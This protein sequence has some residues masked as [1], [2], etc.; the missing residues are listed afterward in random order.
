[1]ELH[2]VITEQSSSCYHKLYI[3]LGRHYSQSFK[4]TKKNG[5]STLYPLLE[6]FSGDGDS[7]CDSLMCT[8]HDHYICGFYLAMNII[9]IS[10]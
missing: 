9:K 1:M 10:H 5:Y 4:K 6:K 3:T 7:Y 8:T 2:A